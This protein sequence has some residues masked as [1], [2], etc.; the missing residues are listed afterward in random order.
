[1]QCSVCTVAAT[2]SSETHW[3]ACSATR[4]GLANQQV[5]KCRVLHYC[6]EHADPLS[7]EEQAAGL[8]QSHTLDSWVC[9]A[10]RLQPFRAAAVGC[11]SS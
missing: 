5:G 7:R 1:M 2:A 6:T 3:K 10:D 8:H 4:W 9:S 11:C